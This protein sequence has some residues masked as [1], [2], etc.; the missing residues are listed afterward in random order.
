MVVLATPCF[1]WKHY[2]EIPDRSTTL[3]SRNTI[4]SKDL[5]SQIV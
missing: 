1:I 3:T 2:S 5:Q 4:D